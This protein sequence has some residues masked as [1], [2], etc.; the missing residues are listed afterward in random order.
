MVNYYFRLCLGLKKD[1]P[2]HGLTSLHFRE[3]QKLLSEE[4][5]AREKVEAELFDA[6]KKAKGA[7]AAGVRK[8]DQ[9]KKIRDLGSNLTDFASCNWVIF[10]A[11]Q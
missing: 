2:F 10:L 4:R 9:D 3:L 1:S 8:D 11:Y 5:R 6:A 7:E